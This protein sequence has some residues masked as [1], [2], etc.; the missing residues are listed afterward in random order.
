MS[1]PIRQPTVFD[2]GQQHLGVQYARALLGA[3]ARNGQAAAVVD[4]LDDLIADVLDRAP[5]LE[6]ILASPRIPVATQL[7]ML[8]KA[9]AGR[10]SATLLTFLKVVC[11][12]RRFACL[13]AIRQA[14]RQQLNAGEGRVEVQVQAATALGDEVRELVTRRLEASLGK[15]VHLVV[16]QDERLIGGLVIRIGDVVYDASVAQGLSRLR[17]SVVD[18]VAR[19]VR[20][21]LDRFDLPDPENHA[22]SEA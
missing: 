20:A 1:E 4:E 11:R 12:R 9:F 5:R 3:A 19:A 18:E 10:M 22:G 21:S 8:D 7:A 16:R 17:D 15:R 14:A 6:A 2:S 13:R